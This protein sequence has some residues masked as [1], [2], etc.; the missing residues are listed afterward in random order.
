MNSTTPLATTMKRFGSTRRKPLVYCN[1]G[2]AVVRQEGLRQ[3]DRRLQR[4]DPARSEEYAFAYI[5]R[6]NRLVRR[7]STTRRSPITTRPSGSIR[8]TPSP[9]AAAARLVCQ[10]GIRQGDRRLQRG[11]PARSQVRPRLLN[12]GRAWSDKKEYDKAIAD[13]SEAIRLDP[14]YALAYYNRGSPGSRKK[15]YDKAI[16]DYTEAIR[17]DPKYALAYNNRGV[18][19]S[20]KKDYDKA[21]AD[22]S[23]AIRLDPKDN[24]AYCNRGDAWRSQHG[25]RQGD[26]RLQ[27]GHPARSERRVCPLRPRRHSVLDTTRWRGS[28]ARTVLDLEGWQR[29]LSQY[30]VLLGHF[31]AGA[32]VGTTT[33]RSSWMRRRADATRPL[34]RTLS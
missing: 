14:K 16:A 17:L 28:G 31:S 32:P 29:R 19:W 1:R 5:D 26:H 23:E 10:E 15:E 3:G 22:Y 13:Y 27:R 30:A 33:Q 20:D 4:G 18:A 8:S 9:T 21:I 12:R 24:A 2:N 34:G 7:T 6:G 25:L 11:H